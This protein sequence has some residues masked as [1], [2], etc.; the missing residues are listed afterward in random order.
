M[1][2]AESRSIPSLNAKA[3]IEKPELP[4]NELVLWPSSLNTLP[5]RRRHEKSHQRFFVL[6]FC[7]GILQQVH[8]A[9]PA[10]DL[11]EYGVA[12]WDFPNGDILD[13][14][15]RAIDHDGIG[16]GDYDV[17]VY[18]PEPVISDLYPDGITS[19]KL[20]KGAMV[21]ASTSVFYGW[22]NLGENYTVPVGDYVFRVTDPDGNTGEAT[23][24][25][26]RRPVDPVSDDALQPSNRL[27]SIVAAFDNVQVRRS[28][29]DWE[30]Y[31]DFDSG[32]INAS[33]WSNPTGYPVV[34]Y[35]AGVVDGRAVLSVQHPIGRG[36]NRLNLINAPETVAGL[37][38]DVTLVGS[39][40]PVPKARVAGYFFKNANTHIWTEIAIYEDRIV[41]DSS[42]DWGSGGIYWLG[43]TLFQQ[44]WEFGS[45]LTGETV[46]A[47]IDWDGSVLT[48]KASVRGEERV[49]SFNT[50][51]LDLAP[52]TDHTKRLESVINLVTADDSPT[53]SW[54]PAEGA[55]RHRVRIYN[56]LGASLYYFHPEA[57]QF[58]FKVPP[59]ILRPNAEYE[60]RVEAYDNHLGLDADN[61]G[62]PANKV[63]F[64]TGPASQV[65]H[66]GLE[67]T[68][69]NVW[70]TPMNTPPYLSCWIKVFDGQGVPESIRS[71]KMV[72]PGGEET[73]L[74][75]DF[76]SSGSP[77]A[78]TSSGIYRSD[79]FRRAAKNGTYT[80][81]VEDVNGNSHSV[82]ETLSV[83]PL[84]PPSNLLINGQPAYGAL[85]GTT[86]ADFSWEEVSGTGFYRLELYDQALNRIYAL[87][88]ENNSLSLPEGFLKEGTLYGVRVTAR[89]EYF[90][91]NID[92]GTASHEEFLMPNF[93]TTGMNG[94]PSFKPTVSLD[95]NLNEPRAGAF[96]WTFP[97]PQD[98]VTPVHWLAFVV[99]VNDADGVPGNIKSVKAIY[100]G[101]GGKQLELRYNSRIDNQTATYWGHEA[102]SSWTDIPSDDYRFIVEDFDGNTSEVSDLLAVAAPL[103]FPDNIWPG[104]EDVVVEINPVIDWDPVPGALAYRLRLYEGWGR[105]I[106]DGPITDANYF[107][108][109]ESL[110]SEGGSYGIRVYAYTENPQSTDVDNVSTSSIFSSEKPQFTV[111][112]IPDPDGDGI[113][114][115][116]DRAADTPSDYFSDGPSSGVIIERGGQ[117]LQIIDRPDPE[118]V[119]LQT[120]AG[121]AGAPAQVEVCGGSAI[122]ELGEGTRVLETCGSVSLNVLKGVVKVKFVSTEGQTAESTITQESSGLTITFEPETFSFSAEPVVTT[123]DDPPPQTAPIEVVADNGAGFSVEAN[124]SKRIVRID[125]K[126]NDPY[127]IFNL[128]GG[129]VLPVAIFGSKTFD[130]KEIKLESLTL[131]GMNVK[132]IGKKSP[133]YL[134]NYQKVDDDGFLDLVIHFADDVGNLDPGSDYAVMSGQLLGGDIFEGSDKLTVRP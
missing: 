123:I 117:E 4:A 124:Q 85:L 56:L 40:S 110:L 63:R 82:S 78:S 104:R 33:L 34:D 47:S 53:I 14:Y 96:V 89:R 111:D 44:T 83:S 58:S 131:L 67:N 23:D 62:A 12:L 99:R 86:A 125:I 10:V 11:A 18:F 108:L 92:N 120:V 132:L 76:K 97:K 116:L 57:G 55:A 74:Y 128:S 43:A 103:P 114:G 41:C 122:L 51:A 5:I 20:T 94:D 90:S 61:V 31:D 80:F 65:P 88:T 126:P 15:I 50:A 101:Q 19:V 102:Y 7:F 79:D 16:E 115:T 9:K 134:A 105:V 60:Y 48:F 27:E 69:V 107:E 68:G 113:Y 93:R 8:A 66:I 25:L 30:P 21:N 91:Q 45:G 13:F 112:L 54:Q 64:R 77:A 119:I 73:P 38:A 39:S 100:P 130:V 70:H 22:L 26:V 2:F 28:G 42:E 127:N 121:N 84:E 49:A 37:R 46:T 129:G 24:V 52:P 75:Y 6:M 3:T 106:Y 36:R 87:V 1:N 71:V 133:K 72:H 98:G 35:P 17:T 118:G 59:G 32:Q 109:P 29:G 81:I 95:A